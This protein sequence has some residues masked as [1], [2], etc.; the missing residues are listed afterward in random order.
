MKFYAMQIFNR[1]KHHDH[2]TAEGFTIKDT[3]AKIAVFLSVAS[4]NISKYHICLTEMSDDDGELNV[5]NQWFG[6]NVLEI[7]N[8]N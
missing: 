5:T 4:E 7:V 3:A 2:V 6:E 8:S 1:E